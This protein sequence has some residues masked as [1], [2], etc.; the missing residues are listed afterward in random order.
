MSARQKHLHVHISLA[1]AIT[2]CAHFMLFPSARAHSLSVYPRTVL[3]RIHDVG[4]L[5]LP[6]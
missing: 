3:V 1:I 5:S 2:L 6:L 4:L